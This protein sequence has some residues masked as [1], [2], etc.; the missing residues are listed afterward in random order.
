MSPLFQ[1][2]FSPWAVVGRSPKKEKQRG[3]SPHPPKTEGV[4]D[5]Q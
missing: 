1:V 2:A 3:E 4:V 5:S